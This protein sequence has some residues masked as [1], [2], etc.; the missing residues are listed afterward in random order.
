MKL[1]ESLSSRLDSGIA[2]TL[3]ERLD[4]IFAESWQDN[5]ENIAAIL[6][7]LRRDMTALDPF[8]AEMSNSGNWPD[9]AGAQSFVLYTSKH[10]LVRINLWFPQSDSQRDNDQYRRYLSIDELHN[11]DFSFFTICLLG[12]GYRTRF[13]HDPCFSHTRNLGNRIEL[14]D[15]GVLQLTEERVLFVEKDVD[16]HMQHWPDEFSVTLNVIPRNIPGKTNIQYILNPRTFEISN[17]IAGE[18]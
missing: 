15:L 14:T 12:P 17:I 16:Y 8:F 7:S 1:F 13:Y 5:Y 3:Y 9:M 11:H 6:V 18:L 10:I 2:G 4:G